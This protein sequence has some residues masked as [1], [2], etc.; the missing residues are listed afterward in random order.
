VADNGRSSVLMVADSLGGGGAE[1]QLTLLAMALAGGW[2]VTVFA[3]GGG[4]FADRL[5]AAGI[6]LEV[7]PRRG[8]F[9]P[10][11]LGRLWSCVGRTRPAVIHSWGWM[12]CLA[13]EPRCRAGGIPHVAGVIRR[14]S[15][16]HRRSLPL[17]LASRLGTLTVANS[18]AGLEAFGVDPRRGRVLPNGFAPERLRQ[19]EA[20]R[21]DR[22]G[23]VAVMA[24][25]MDARKDFAAVIAAARILD[26]KRPGLFRFACLGGGEDYGRLRADAAD[27]VASGTLAMPGRVDEVLDRYGEA[28]VGVMLST[29]IH[30]EGLSNSIME[31]MACGLPVVCTDQGGNRELVAD[32]RT[33]F[34]VP[35]ADP[36]AVAARLEWLA[37]HPGEAAAMGEAGHRRIAEEFSVGTMLARAEAIYAEAIAAVRG[38]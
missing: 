26:R 10:R 4:V 36:D 22:R 34:L 30:G 31:Y 6:P 32:G 23:N 15:L 17:R 20:G 3:L 12:S 11:P 38:G 2:D 24:A 5:A 16:P 19:A 35:V 7:A 27:L 1:R 37:D 18:R 8:R 21:R 29:A 33:G 9:D 28:S 14:G 25:T 13:V